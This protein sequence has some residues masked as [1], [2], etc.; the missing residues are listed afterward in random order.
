MLATGMGEID[1]NNFTGRDVDDTKKSQ[2][3]L[4]LHVDLTKTGMEVIN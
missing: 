1:V 3:D 4:R 2:N